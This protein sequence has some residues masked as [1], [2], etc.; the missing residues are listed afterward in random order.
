MREIGD[1]L[2]VEICRPVV[3]RPVVRCPDSDILRSRPMAAHLGKIVEFDMDGA[4]LRRRVVLTAMDRD[5]EISQASPVGH[6]VGNALP[7]TSGIVHTPGGD[8]V[9]KVLAVIAETIT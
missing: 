9:V 3:N 2:Q 1:R 6:F 8:A 7:G 4:V 5:H